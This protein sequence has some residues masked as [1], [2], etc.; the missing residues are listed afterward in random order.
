V[1][2]TNRPESIDQ[3]YR[4]LAFCA[5]AEGFPA[6]YEQLARQ[7]EEFTAW[8]DLPI[9]AELHGMAP[10]LRYHIIQSGFP[11]PEETKRILTGLYLRHREFNKVQT[12]SLVRI[13]ALFEQSGIRPLL[14]KGLGLAYQYYPEPALRPISDI[15]L[16]VQASE[17]AEV[18]HLLT[19]AGYNP[20]FPEPHFGW[21]SKEMV[22]QSPFK[23]GISTRMEIHHYDQSHRVYDDLSHDQ[24]FAGF[25]LPPVTISIE[26]QAIRMPAPTDNIRYL[27][28]HIAHHLPNATVEKPLQLKWSADIISLVE[29]HADSIDWKFIRKRDPATLG[30]LEVLFSITP[31]HP[32]CS[33]IIPIRQLKSPQGVNQYPTGWPKQAFRQ[34]KFSNLGQF[35][36][37]TFKPPSEWWLRLYYGI[38][39]P[40][41]FWYGWLLYPLRTLKMLFLALVRSINT[42]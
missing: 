40:F 9:Q 4:L 35:W 13:M 25:E 29:R 24:E 11:I 10:L 19:I 15:D 12:Q 27:S 41:V 26:G 33:K 30:R 32:N 34:I 16:L 14:L 37:Q 39:Q 17:V 7:L 2:Q 18:Q 5:R 20:T 42:G 23:N 28:R 21:N 1:D 38:Y 31:L 22:A 8:S 36:M 3:T 6:F